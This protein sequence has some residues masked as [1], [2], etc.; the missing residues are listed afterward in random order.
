MARKRIFISYDYE[1]DAHYK[2]LLLA[3]S[4]NADFD[5]EVYNT[6]VKVGINSS[7]ATYI[8]SK[9]KP[10]ITWA[11]YLLVL[12][13]RRPIKAIGS[14]GRFGPLLRTRKD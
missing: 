6:S 1:N 4:G 5:F 12:S 3:W 14:I 2:N 8:K 11:S 7:D 10:M 13:E 9:I